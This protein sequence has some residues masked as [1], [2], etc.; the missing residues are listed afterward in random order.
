M[1]YCL[2]KKDKEYH[3]CLNYVVEKDMINFG[4]NFIAAPKSQKPCTDS[5]GKCIYSSYDD[6]YFCV[7]PQ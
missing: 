5:A 3:S 4:D 1:T 7:P 2:S 6:N